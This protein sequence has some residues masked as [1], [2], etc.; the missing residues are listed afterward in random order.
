MTVR[1]ILAWADAYHEREGR[2][3]THIS[4][5]I[6]E[7][8][9]ETWSR[10]HDAL[11]QGLRGFHGGSSLA[12]L[13]AKHR[14]RRNPAALPRLVIKQILSWADEHHKRTGEWP[15]HR[16]GPV[17]NS[18]GETWLKIDQA[19]R[20]GFRG[21]RGGSSLSQTLA[22]YRNKRH[23][24]ALP[25]LTVK[26]ILSWAD[27]HRKLTGR[28]PRKDSGKVHGAPGETWG[29]VNISLRLGIR[30]LTSGSTLAERLVRHRGAIIRDYKP[31]LT[32]EYILELADRHHERTG[33][34]PKVTS[35]AVHGVEGENWSAIS[36]CLSKGERGLPGGSSLAL[37]LYLCRHVPS[38]PYQARYTTRR[39]LVWCDAYYGRHGRWPT[40]QSGEIYG[41]RGENWRKVDNALRL[42]LRGM[43]GGSSLARLLDK[44][45]R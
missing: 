28:W 38:Q 41:A 15:T 35:G 16:S 26:Q 30:G 1:Q 6:P 39:I 27:A 45:R 13:L 42:G 5:R 32:I 19:L 40:A 34:W 36:Q 8:E 12:R 20:R 7:A 4:G 9:D 14:E 23:H 3:P 11:Y 17:L 43:R 31:L 24:L 10:V 44:H 18:G 22:R 33:K 2:W 37:L 25:R 29:G 21:F